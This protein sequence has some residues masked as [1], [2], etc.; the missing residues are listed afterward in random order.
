MGTSSSSYSWLIQL[1]GD[2]P[3]FTT[4]CWHTQNH[5]TASPAYTHRSEQHVH[6]KLPITMPTT[7][8][9][10]LS[11]T[12][13][14]AKSGKLTTSGCL[15]ATSITSFSTNLQVYV[16][17]AEHMHGCCCHNI[18][19]VPGL[20]PEGGACQGG[21]RADCQ[22][23][24]HQHPALAGIAHLPPRSV[25]FLLPDKIGDVLPLWMWADTEDADGGPQCSH[26][27]K[28]QVA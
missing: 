8:F 10:Y 18:Q 24:G 19:E 27:A 25:V 6:F 7:A 15:T 28:Q 16:R 9:L 23:C 22:P 3:L 20:V 11:P 2:Q 5:T 13:A 4:A 1:S 21:S 14:M 26:I 17:Q 12:R